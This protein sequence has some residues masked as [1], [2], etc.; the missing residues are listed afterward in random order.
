[1]YRVLGRFHP[2]RSRKAPRTGHWQPVV[3]VSGS[4]R[5]RILDGFLVQG[6]RCDAEPSCRA[7]WAGKAPEN[8]AALRVAADDRCLH[9]PPDGHIPTGMHPHPPCGSHIQQP[10]V[11]N[12][13]LLT[14]TT[15]CLGILLRL[16][17]GS[18]LRRRASGLGIRSADRVP[19][20]EGRS[21][22]G[23][24]DGGSPDF[25]PAWSEVRNGLAMSTIERI[26]AIIRRLSRSTPH[27]RRL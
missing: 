17:R 6:V 12:E 10:C 25:S 21:L 14:F 5:Q 8:A 13:G 26:S 11:R 20:P 16:R 7:P 23:R 2:R 3:K 19:R 24:E 9:L 18:L 22:A 4:S 27:D 15:G 1:M